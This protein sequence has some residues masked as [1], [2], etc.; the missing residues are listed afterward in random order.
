[1]TNTAGTETRR[2]GLERS[3]RPFLPHGGTAH[4]REDGAGGGVFHLQLFVA[5]WVVVHGDAGDGIWRRLTRFGLTTC[6]AT[7][8]SR[9]TRRMG[10]SETVFALPGQSPGIKVG[11][12]IALFSKS[13]TTASS[14]GKRILYRDFHQAKA[15]ERRQALLDSLDA[16]TMDSGY[17]FL[18]PNLGLGLP[19]KP[20]PVSDNWFRLASLART[21]PG[22]VSWCEDQPGWVSR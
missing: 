18:E 11:T 17:S 3:V 21:V 22:L 6:M 12:S 10:T 5:G 1:M 16:P 20:T 9:N 4:C 8:S 15:I 2:P 7:A 14:G 19:F 13:G